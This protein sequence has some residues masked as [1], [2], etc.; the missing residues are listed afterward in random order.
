MDKL[1]KQ[2]CEEFKFLD[3]LQTLSSEE[4]A[5]FLSE[6]DHFE[7]ADDPSIIH[8]EEGETVEDWIRRYDLHDISSF[9][10]Y[11]NQ[12]SSND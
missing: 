7:D 3:W 5:K 12:L 4:K 8:L 11:V 1:R 2:F 9:I 6:S 10:E